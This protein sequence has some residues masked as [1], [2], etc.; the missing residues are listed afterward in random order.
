MSNIYKNCPVLET[1]HFILRLVKESDAE[2]LLNCYSDE[3]TQSLFNA[4]NCTSDFCFNT[5]D[6][7]QKCI[8][9][10]ILAYEQ[11]SFVRFA[12][13]NK[14]NDEAIGT[15]EMFGSSGRGIL[16]IDICFNHENIIS[17]TELINLCINNFYDLFNVNDILTKAVPQAKERIKSL[18]KTGFKLYDLK[19]RE[20]YFIRSK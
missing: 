10:W 15:I 12:I 4:D 18:L 9:S 14:S 16:R 20:H 11:E 6:D 13:I 19:G 1:E 17:L 5:L 7:I 8:A 2:N 3:R